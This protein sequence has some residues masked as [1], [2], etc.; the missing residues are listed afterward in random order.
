MK[1]EVQDYLEKFVDVCKAILGDRLVGLYLE[2]SLAQDDFQAR[3]D[4]D[5][6]GVCSE[7]LSDE[8]KNKLVQSVRHSS[9]PV[10]A[11][12]LELCIVTADTVKH[13]SPVPQYELLFATGLRWED[14][15][16]LSGTMSELLIYFS[17]C[18]DKGK[19]LYGPNPAEVFS[20][21][22]P[23][24]ILD[25]T[26]EQIQW[27]QTKILDGVDDPRGEQAVLNA[28]RAWYFAEEKVM[29][30]KS[31]GAKWVLAKEPDNKLV[32]DA[33]ALRT[34][35]RTE[36]LDGKE[37]EAFLSRIL[38]ACQDRRDVEGLRALDSGMLSV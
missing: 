35:E 31:E 7:P 10:P 4:I 33:L 34:G 24:W 17:I 13:P 14:K 2:G 25:P 19:A 5:I 21:V 27:H 30:S 3:S 9:L 12:G 15:S 23:A 20:P 8:I 28:C 11:D 16:V 37:I 18:R 22:P 38:K 26:I 1:K 32:Q 36:P 29:R 6:V